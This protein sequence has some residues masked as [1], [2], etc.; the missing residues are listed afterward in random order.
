MKNFKS[1]S[2]VSLIALT[3][4]VFSCTKTEFENNEALTPIEIPVD[5][6]SYVGS[7]AV[8]GSYIGEI[9]TQL[10]E[11][12]DSNPTVGDEELNLFADKLMKS[13]DLEGKVKLKLAFVNMDS[14]ILSLLNP[15][16][17]LLYKTNKA[18]ALL[19]MANGTLA[20]AYSQSNYIASSLING[21]GDAFRHAIWCFGMTLDVQS[22]FAKAWSDAHENGTP[23]NP[24][25]EKT[26]DL[27][28]NAIGIQ[29]GKDNPKMIKNNAFILKT[30]ECVRSGKLK[31][32]KNKQIAWSD[33]TGE[34]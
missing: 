27:Y 6:I 26:M 5:D 20:L 2:K 29:L 31:I 21:N 7:D 18:K 12:K 9:A 24:E 1:I 28:N 17:Q 33:K 10:R 25:I 30:K 3:L 19:C 4:F 14:Y 13:P 15:K 11:Y 22:T 34:K 32:I 23:N 16:E 8:L